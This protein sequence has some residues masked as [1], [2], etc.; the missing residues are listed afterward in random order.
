MRILFVGDLQIGTNSR[1]LFDGLLAEG[2]DTRG[3]DI[4]PSIRP[5]RLSRLWHSLRVQKQVTPEEDL[6]IRAQV[7]ALHTAMKPQLLIAIKTIHYDQSTFLESGIPVAVHVSFDDVSNSFNTSP[8][9]M[10]TEAAWSAIVTTKKHNVDELYSRGAQR[11]Q[12]IW[13]AYDPL[14]RR[15][16]APLLGR[17][18]QI[19]F[20][21]AA[22]PDRIALPMELARLAPRSSAVYGPQWRR[23]YPLGVRGTFIPGNATA[24]NYTKA[25]NSIQIGLVLLNSDNRDMHTN[26]SFETPATGQL[27]LAQR[28]A[29]HLEILAEDREALYFEAKEE[30][31]EKYQFAKANPAAMERLAEAGYERITRGAN[32]WQNRAA[33]IVSMASEL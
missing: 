18:Y 20:I 5:R 21:G 3:V 19:G 26:R 33:E 17:P 24:S 13:G 1:S 27:V 4:S 30:L 22:R 2:H 31:Q 28:T 32:T 10:E 7:G 6:R 11:V 25:A 9:Y 8:R 15:R 12:F 14:F 23:H 16:E 29:E